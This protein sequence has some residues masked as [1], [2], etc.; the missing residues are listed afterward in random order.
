MFLI[1]IKLWLVIVW[2]QFVNYLLIWAFAVI[3]WITVQIT[4]EVLNLASSFSSEASSFQQPMDR[5]DIIF[6]SLQ[7]WTVV[8]FLI[9]K[10]KIL[11]TSF[12]LKFPLSFT[13]KENFSLI[14]SKP[15][16][17]IYEQWSFSSILSLRYHNLTTIFSS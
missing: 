12:L 8:A 4:F 16:V 10:I 6:A 13:L 5:F 2:F 17:L 7:E 14:I 15:I 11:L 1:L 9:Q 3:L